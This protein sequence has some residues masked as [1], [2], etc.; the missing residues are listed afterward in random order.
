M[1]PQKIYADSPIFVDSP[2]DAFALSEHTKIDVLLIFTAKWC[3]ACQTLKT[4][5]VNNT[6][7]IEDKIVCYVDYDKRPDM[8]KEY[9]VRIIPDSFIYSK[10]KEIKR[11]TGYTSKKEYEKWILE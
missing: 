8:V 1:I 5:L 10:M 3:G 6:S 7:M 11:K 9:S 4:D 2:E